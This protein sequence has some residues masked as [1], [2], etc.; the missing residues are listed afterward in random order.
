MK[1]HWFARSTVL[2]LSAAT[3]GFATFSAGAETCNDIRECADKMAVIVD[4]LSTEVSSL[5]DKI[6]TLEEA[7]SK[8][9]PPGAVVAFDSTSCPEGWAPYRPA[10]G[11]F[12]RGIDRSGR[13]IDPDGQ[14]AP[15][16]PQGDAFRRHSHSYERFS[17]RIDGGQSVR[18]DNNDAILEAKPTQIVG[19]DETRPKNVALL[20]CRRN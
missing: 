10:Y 6:N 7:L 5:R 20:Y 12:I 14:R 18:W 13:R 4:G 1:F 11:K 16:D 9:V 17:S 15:G 8:V 19:G 2:S 3:I